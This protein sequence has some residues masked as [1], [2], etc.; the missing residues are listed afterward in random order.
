MICRWINAENRAHLWLLSLMSSL[1]VF[2]VLFVHMLTT[3]LA[4]FSGR[5]IGGVVIHGV[6][7]SLRTMLYVVSFFALAGTFLLSFILLGHAD[8]IIR[9]RVPMRYVAAEFAGIAQLSAFTILIGAFD[10]LSQRQFPSGVATLLLIFIAFTCVLVLLKAALWRRWPKLVELYSCYPLIVLLLT[11]PFIAVTVY[12]IYSRQVCALAPRHWMGYWSVVAIC[13][14]ATPLIVWQ[15]QKYPFERLVRALV[16]AGAALLFIPM[17]IPLAQELHY[18]LSEQI[19]ASPR[20][21]A[22]LMSS[23]LMLVSGIILL[24][25]LKRRCLE[26]VRLEKVIN[27][28][29]LPLILASLAMYNYYHHTFIYD[30]FDLLHQGQVV[31][32]AHQFFNYG[33]VP[34]IDI[35]PV[36]GLADI[37]MASPME[38][39]PLSL[40]AVIVYAVASIVFTPCF[41]FLLVAAT[42]V[43]MLLYPYMSSFW[44]G[45]IPFLILYLILGVKRH[46]F[47]WH[48]ILWVCAMAGILW[49]YDTGIAAFVAT[50]LVLS[51]RLYQRCQGRICLPR[52]VNSAWTSCLLV[53]VTMFVAYVAIAEFRGHNPL[54]PLLQ[55]IRFLS[56]QAQSQS[57]PVF[58]PS[59]PMTIVEYIILPL[60]GIAYVLYGV[61]ALIQKRKLTVNELFLLGLALWSLIYSVKNVQRHCLLELFAYQCFPFLL[62][63]LPSLF[64]KKTIWARITFLIIFLGYAL[65]T[66]SAFAPPSM[67]PNMLAKERN[68]LLSYWIPNGEV[69]TIFEFRSAA[70]GLPRVLA[71]DKSQYES[72]DRYLKN[73]LTKDET[74]VD[75]A[76]APMLYSL[77]N[78][79]FPSFFISAVLWVGDG[80][81]NYVISRL[82]TLRL[83]GHL[84]LVVFK[85][86]S[87]A[88][89]LYDGVAPEMRSYRVAEYFYKHYRPL[90]V[91]HK[92]ELWVAK[93]YDERRMAGV[94]TQQT[95]LNVPLLDADSRQADMSSQVS[96]SD[97]I[98]VPGP[99]LLAGNKDHYLE[100]C[101]RSSAVGPLGVKSWYTNENGETIRSKSQ[102]FIYKTGAMSLQAI[103][104]VALRDSNL[105]LTY[106][107][108]LPPPQTA[109]SHFAL[110]SAKILSVPP[111]SCV[112]FSHGQSFLLGKLPFLWG[113][114]DEKC[115]AY[116]TPI[117]HSLSTSE[118][119][120]KP[121]GKIRFSVPCNIDKSTGNYLHLRM[122]SDRE[123]TCRIEYGKRWPSCI[124]FQITASKTYKDYLIRI[125]SQWAWMEEPVD[126]LLLESSVLVN[127]EKVYMRKGD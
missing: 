57:Y 123:G 9:A 15:G 33:M 74:F 126:S 107:Q 103:I 40:S 88:T 105:T 108:F 62:C 60:V 100:I 75:F 18:Q 68:I 125:S 27:F 110:I 84:P 118:R 83:R 61:M 77:T 29:Y 50:S 53:A 13:M 96:V 109:K 17:C 80:I 122:R 24:L 124:E 85:H 92:C 25:T 6:D 20:I 42:P 36:H 101:Y 98:N 91:V 32:L 45:L 95:P 89:D 26:H 94:T 119:T 70:P 106:L 73:V 47:G 37:F 59:S 64:L 116:S 28:V 55:A 87:Y 16:I 54:Q 8:R 41:A 117:L 111:G 14:V 114:Y 5:I 12:W 120:V 78:R 21:L 71:R 34:F 35:M 112:P 63:A 44:F 115:A 3:P 10:L 19:S 1:W 127:I 48:V 102:M 67:F 72:L 7:A 46:S 2:H 51:V 81:Q 121:G 22:M 30:S 65:I 38:W 104:P 11:L 23:I 69:K 97:A 99:V 113:E 52:C 90:G 66:A 58:W 76:N 79:R 82:D 56:A 49:Q 4:H 86:F 93:D 39:F 31:I 43:A